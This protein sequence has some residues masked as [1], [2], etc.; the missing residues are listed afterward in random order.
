MGGNK[1]TKPISYY[2]THKVLHPDGGTIYKCAD[3]ICYENTDGQV[4]TLIEDPHWDDL[5][6]FPEHRKL[7]CSSSTSNEYYDL[8]DLDELAKT[9]YKPSGSDWFFCDKIQAEYAT[10]RYMF[11]IPEDSSDGLVICAIDVKKMKTYSTVIDNPF[12]EMEDIDELSIVVKDNYIK[13]KATDYE[14]HV[15]TK[16]LSWDPIKRKIDG[17]KMEADDGYM[18]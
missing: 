5:R 2:G 13:L 12:E 15:L 10:D 7:I 6:V 4:C 17:E 11:L 16:K 1:K 14:D 3:G 8:Y 18:A 9:P